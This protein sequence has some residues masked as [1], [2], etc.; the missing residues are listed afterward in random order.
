[1]WYAHDDKL[2]NFYDYQPFGQWKTLPSTAVKQ[3]KLDSSDCDLA[4][5]SNINYMVG[6]LNY[7]LPNQNP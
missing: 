2:P 3:F 1:L 5:G 6:P 4:G 7:A